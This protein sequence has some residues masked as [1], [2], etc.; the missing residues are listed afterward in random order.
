MQ[1]PVLERSSFG[2]LCN[3][4]QARGQQALVVDAPRLARLSGGRNAAQRVSATAAAVLS[5]PAPP[6]VSSL[7]QTGSV[8]PAPSL[9]YSP[10]PATIEDVGVL[11]R[12]V[13]GKVNLITSPQELKEVLNEYKDTAVVLKCK[14]KS[15]RPCMAFRKPYVRLA[16]SNPDALFL[17]I[18]GDA[19]AE[20][21]RLMID[22]NVKAT[23][24]F[25]IYK[26]NE[27]VDKVVGINKEKLSSAV[28]SAQFGFSL[29]EA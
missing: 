5:S 6:P 7:K 18:L 14:A 13:R 19:S 8:V 15:C 4:G 11:D 10:D 23:P 17:E 28:H 20:N 2:R 16:E 25:R 26:E 1:Q 22:Y 24:T 29:V 27:C 9:G 3:E 12:I 21:R